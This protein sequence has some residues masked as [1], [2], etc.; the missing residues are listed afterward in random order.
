MVWFGLGCFFNDI[1]TFV[2]YFMP[3]PSFSKKSSGTI[4]RRDGVIRG[5]HTFLKGICPK[6][7]VIMIV[8][9]KLAS[10]D[11][12]VQLLNHCSSG[13]PASN[14]TLW[15]LNRRVYHDG[16][17]QT[18]VALSLKFQSDPHYNLTM[19]KSDEHTKHRLSSLIIMFI[20]CY[21]S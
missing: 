14:V 16:S 1:S 7:N 9:F 11:I 10:H 17:W 12:L 20:R 21:T 5:D 2:G 8:E 19:K 15:F 13:T 6:V 18:L 4:Q 3:K